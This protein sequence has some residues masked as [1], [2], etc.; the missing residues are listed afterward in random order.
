M[1]FQLNDVLI[2]GDEVKEYIIRVDIT[3][4]YI[5]DDILHIETPDS[6]IDIKFYKEKSLREGYLNIKKYLLGLNTGL[7]LK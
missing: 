2:D 6:K 3:D 4:L 1:Y 5:R 7:T